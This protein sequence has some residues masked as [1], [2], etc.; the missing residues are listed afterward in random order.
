MTANGPR[1]STVIVNGRFSLI[2]F[3]MAKFC[4]GV[5]ALREGQNTAVLT[6]CIITRLLAFKDASYSKCWFTW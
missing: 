4:Y 2:V 1:I 3:G 6:L 5:I